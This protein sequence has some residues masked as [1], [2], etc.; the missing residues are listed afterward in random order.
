MAFCRTD[1]NER[2]QRIANDGFGQSWGGY[3]GFEEFKGIIRGMQ[4]YN[5]LLTLPQ[6]DSELAAPGS[7]V[8][9]WY[10]NLNPT[11]ADISDKSG[12][13]HHPVW[14]GADR[15]ALWTN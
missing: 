13:N 8:R 10:L 11:P 5:S 3:A 12:S 4:F 15:P 6:I 7:A 9:P 14:E 1:I 2:F